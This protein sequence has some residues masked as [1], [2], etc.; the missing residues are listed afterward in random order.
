MTT[1]KFQIVEYNDEIRGSYTS[2]T[3]QDLSELLQYSDH[4]SYD[5]Q[6]SFDNEAEAR[7]YFEKTYRNL[8]RTYR[9]KGQGIPFLDVCYYHLDKEEYNEDGEF[10]YGETI[11]EIYEPLTEEQGWD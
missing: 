1:T 4:N 11:A 2:L 6:E 8:A 7:A 9:R 10:I 5:F 3:E